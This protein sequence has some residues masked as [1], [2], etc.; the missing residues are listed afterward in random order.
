MVNNVITKPAETGLSQAKSGDVVLKNNIFSDANAFVVAQ[1]MSKALSSSTIVPKDYRGNMG[2]CLIALDLATRL[3][4]SPLLIMQ[5]LYIIHGRPAWYTQYIIAMINN[6]KKYKTELQFDVSGKGDSLSCYA[7]V[8]DYSGHI[9]K[10]PTITMAMAKAEGWTSRDGSKWKTMPEVMIR[11]RAASF[12]GRLNC[13]E[14]VMGIYSADE[15]IEEVENADYAIVDEMV[16]KDLHQEAD[17]EPEAPKGE[18]D[19]EPEEEQQTEDHTTGQS[20][21]DDFFDDEPETAADGQTVIDS[22]LK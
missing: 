2:N 3:N 4:T 19:P 14:M 10:G 18:D 9:V 6:S 7:F 1:R 12:F 15:V 17:S 13:P 20:V 11:Y 22:R 5:N 16:A 21:I 8:E